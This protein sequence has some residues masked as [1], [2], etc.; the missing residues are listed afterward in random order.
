MSS[1]PDPWILF[2]YVFLSNPGALALG[3]M[4]R[5]IALEFLAAAATTGAM[6]KHVSLI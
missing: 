5:W 3:R 2:G 6:P 4:R 1:A